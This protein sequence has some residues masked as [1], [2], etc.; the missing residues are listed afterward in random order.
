MMELY[1]RQLT[2]KLC[3]IPSLYFFAWNQIA[4]LRRLYFTQRSKAAKN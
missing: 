2:L 3:G 1:S 4:E